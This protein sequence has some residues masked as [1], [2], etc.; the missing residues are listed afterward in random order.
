M[1]VLGVDGGDLGGEL[2]LGRGALLAGRL[3]GEPLIE[4]GTSYRQDAA[5]PLYAVVGAVFGD[6]P[7]AEG[8]RPISL[9]K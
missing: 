5:Q 8:H 4:A 9:A 2:V 1:A 3:A 6:E 7:V